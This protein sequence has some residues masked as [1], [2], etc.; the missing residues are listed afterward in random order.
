MY[1]KH[2]KCRICKEDSE[3]WTVCDGCWIDYNKQGERR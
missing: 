2:K 1:K 3:G